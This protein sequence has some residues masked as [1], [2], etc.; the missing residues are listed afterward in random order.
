MSCRR[1]ERGAVAVLVGILSVALLVVLA[2][3]V[4][5]GMAYAQRQAL[6]TGADSAAMAIVQMQRTA[7]TKNPSRTCPQIV[8]ADGALAPTD[9]AKASSIALTQINRNAPFGFALPAGS[10]TTT[11]SCV[12]SNKVLQAKVK[13][14]KAQKRTVGVLAGSTDLQ[15]N[16]AATAVMGVPNSV[17]GVEP[18]AVCKHQAQAILNDAAAD[19]AAGIPYRAELIS[20]DKVWAGNATCDGSGGAG[21]WGW[22]DL[23]QGNGASALGDMIASGSSSPL[24]LTGSPPA[25]AMDGTPGNKGN[26]GPVH[27][28]MQAIMDKQVMLP[29]Y[30][31]YSGNGANAS[32][33]VT[34]FIAVQVCGY[35]KSIKGTCYDPAV[36]MSGDDLQVRF[37][38]FVEAGSID[39]LCAIGASCAY[40]YDVEMVG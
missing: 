15:L 37:I 38:G 24:T 14:T 34:G 19:L 7:Q 20:S 5:F 23:G 30:T 25:V 8:A 36:P 22:L 29:V 9:P 33:T 31:T 35:D 16:R 6:G 10:V 28:G 40:S 17:T 13:V 11:L 18:L 2:F 4:D 27:D 1:D 21:N 12:S 39:T 32:Y 3:T 26:S